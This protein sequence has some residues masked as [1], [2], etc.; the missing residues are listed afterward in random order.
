MTLA[1]F[2]AAVAPS[3]GQPLL[4]N[5]GFRQTQTAYTARIFHEQGV[6]LLHP[7]LPVLGEPF[8]VPFEFPLFQ[9][10]ASLLMEVGLGDD[11]AM[12][13]AGVLCF[14]GTALLLYGLVRHVAGRASGVAALVAFVATPF[15]LVWGRASMIEYLATAGAVGFT[16]ATI[17]WRESGR[18]SAAALALAA[19]L[20]AMLVKPT[21]AVFWIIPALAYRPVL[22]RKEGSRTR[23]RVWLVV[24]VLLPIAASGLWTRHAD[25]IKAA[26]PNTAW[27]TSTE[28]ARWTFGSRS[29]RLDPAVWG[30]VGGRV[31]AHVI[32]I[33]G[34]AMLAVAAV[35]LLRSTQRWFWLGIVTA[36][37]LPPLVYTN[38]YVIHDY[39]LAAVSP[40]FA[41]LLGLGAGFLW[42]LVPRDLLAQGVLVA[43]GLLLVSST[44]ALDR[45]YWR[46]VYMDDPDPETLT[47]A[48]ELDERTQPGDR[49][50]VV[51]LD[52]SP[53]VLYYAH[54]EGLMVVDAFARAAYESIH[55]D[56]YRH[57]LVAYP[58]DTDLRPLTRWRWLGALGPHT[59]GIADTASELPESRVVATNAG[60][61]PEGRPLRGGVQIRCGRPTRIPSGGHGTLIRLQT[62]LPTTTVTVAADLAPLPARRAL[63]VAPG[64]AT[65]GSIPLTCSGRRSMRVDVFDA[66]SPVRP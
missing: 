4:D 9:A 28:L 61:L 37:V 15:A 7:K 65:A 25:A 36:A 43:A 58:S 24:L 57:L 39:Y 27:L 18:A 3:L 48:R 35:A 32:G 44:F 50:A 12:R 56:A 41:A 31:A 13:I 14:L 11:V 20:V 19:G 22:A 49:I 51:G 38:L 55:R 40:A 2:V 6:D 23:E 1:A 45:G 42:R 53:A 66:S 30:T 54:R 21:T 26:N 29:Q 34:V 63:F 17:S 33:A 52:W 62:A 16:W 5:H 64:L 47:L 60:Q 46:S 8:E 10:G 59:Y